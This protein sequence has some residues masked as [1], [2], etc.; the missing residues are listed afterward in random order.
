M[1][2]FATNLLAELTA[3]SNKSGTAQALATAFGADS[4]GSIGQANFQ[5]VFAELAIEQPTQPSSSS[6]QATSYHNIK[7]TIFEC[8]L[9]PS[10]SN[11]Y[12]MAKYQA[13]EMMQ[14]LDSNG[15]GSVS[16]SELESFNTSKAPAAGTTTDPAGATGAGATSGSG[17]TSST[18][19]GATTSPSTDTT[20]PA[21][22]AAPTFIAMSL[23]SVASI[24]ETASASAF[25]DSMMRSFDIAGNGYFTASDVQAAFTKDPTLGDATKAQAI[26]SELDASGDGQV[27]RQELIDGYQQ[28]D[29]VSNLLGAYDPNNAGYIDTTALAGKIA[30]ISPSLNAMLNSWDSDKNGQLTSAKL[31]AGI[32]ASPMALSEMFALVGAV[33]AAVSAQSAMAEYDTSNKGYITTADLTAAW[34]ASQ[35]IND[36]AN[37]QSAIAAWDANGDGQ[38]NLG[39]MIAGQQVTDV[40]NQ[41]L[42]QFDPG[43]QGFIDVSSAGAAAMAAAPSLFNVLKS[44][45]A[46]S[47][48][49]LTEPEI[50][51]G[52]RTS[53]AKHQLAAR[54][55]DASTQTDPGSLA[56]STMSQ[57]DANT[58]GQIN[59]GE[60]LN[61]AGSNPAMSADPVST[62]NA[63]DTN[64]DGYLTL[65]EM[66]TGIQTIQQAQAIVSQYDT[67]GKGYFD[68]TDMEAA[69]QSMDPTTAPADIA[70]Q[71]QQIMGFWDANGDGQVTVQDVIQ[72]VKSGGYVGGQQLAAQTAS[73]AA[74]ST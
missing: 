4:S 53:N 3:S 48:G 22:V 60:F 16:L 1:A 49:K 73:G 68:V 70:T 12:A 47:D 62:F 35:G 33:N 50:M 51:N 57:I 61:Y 56:V 15:D 58:D 55:Q 13:S 44:W 26:I 21:P 20:P 5:R 43:A 10:Y 31:L 41:L 2:D 69:L 42:S 63:W 65:D 38:V 6:M 9:Y 18:A 7:R 27:T 37:A 72:G 52:L 17:S 11:N 34:S 67:A 19:T 28:L 29:L 25:A 59:L 64:S 74:A 30:S 23:T 40:T 8:Q 66:Q 71:A 14:A 54:S 24:A 32:K 36:P 45:D 39:E 46:D